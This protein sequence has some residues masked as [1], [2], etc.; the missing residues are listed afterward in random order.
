MAEQSEESENTLQR[1]Q[2]EKADSEERR[3]SAGVNLACST[4]D[5]A[6]WSGKNWHALE[7]GW[8]WQR[9]APHGSSLT[10][11]RTVSN[12]TFGM[13]S[14]HG[15]AKLGYLISDHSAVEAGWAAK[16]T[17]GAAAATAEGTRGACST[18]SHVGKV[19]KGDRWANI[20]QGFSH[21][22]WFPLNI[23]TL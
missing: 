10:S 21:L 16:A 2:Q 17:G 18:Q 9:E 6:S 4:F 13:V 23:K 12:H 5:R 15:T 7:F 3:A 19:V 22:H 1:L 14:P 20:H 8:I 11:S